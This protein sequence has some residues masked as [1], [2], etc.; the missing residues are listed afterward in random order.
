MQG[1]CYGKK[2]IGMSIRNRTNTSKETP[3][4][5]NRHSRP[6][7]FAAS[8]K[9]LST[10]RQWLYIVWNAVCLLGSACVLAVMSLMLAYGPYPSDVFFGYF[11]RPTIFLLNY[12]PILLL[13][14]LLFACTGRQWIA[15]LGTSLL[16]ITASVCNYYKLTLRSDPVVFSDLSLLFTAVGF[17]GKYDIQLCKRVVLA[18]ATVP[19]GTVFLLLHARGSFGWKGRVALALCAVLPLYPLWTQVYSKYKVYSSPAVSNAQFINQFSETQQMIS[20]GF[21]YPFFYSA[22]R[23]IEPEPEGYLTASVEEDLA[24]FT[25]A[26]IAENKKVN[27]LAIQLEAFADLEQLGL[28]GID[29]SAYADYRAL[30]EDSYHGTL[31]TNIFSG[32]TV[33]TERCFLTGSTALRQYARN[34]PSYVWYLKSQGYQAI[35]SHPCTWEF[36]S[37][38]SINENLGFDTYDFM[39]NRFNQLTTNKVAYDDILFPELLRRYEEA[40]QAGPVFDFV[41]TYQGHG[42]YNTEQL[43]DSTPLWSAEDCSDEVYYAMNNYLSS[44]KSTGAHLKELTQA[45]SESDTPVVVLLY[46]DHK[47][48]MGNDAAYYH[49]L[50]INFDL[51][52][53]EGVTN[54]YGTEYLLWANDAA[55][56]QL[57][58]SFR[59][60]GPTTCSGFLMNVVFDVL[61][62]KGPAYM[63]LANEVRQV[64]PVVTSTGVW[65]NNEG[66]VHTLSPEENAQYTRLLYAQ[67]YRHRQFGRVS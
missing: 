47:P 16:F 24:T 9:G 25:D 63:Q 20:R 11:T 51:S 3:D 33:D 2:G 53:Q 57:G 67:Y 21:V 56:K 48:W 5:K 28:T 6:F 64:L 29:A 41:V 32:G 45:L 22:I 39:E 26:S 38:R 10:G 8:A 54:Y 49:E 27:I 19:L 52:T 17:A 40:A 36:Y 61:G 30:R 42:P 59:G 23:V 15:Y 13:Q 62:W 4:N 31:I 43:I 46:G 7:L 12:L 60:E 58:F 14:L 37:R 18:V 50:G 1:V 65:M 66:L 34:T 35:G 55:K 44:V